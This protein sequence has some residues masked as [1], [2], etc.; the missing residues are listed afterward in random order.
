MSY[1]E[2][3]DELYEEQKSMTPDQIAE[4]MANNSEYS[5][6]LNNLPGVKHVWVDRGAVMSC[7]GA[8]H[9]SHR[10]FKVKK[11]RV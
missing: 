11:H 10:H 4:D 8:N 1:A 2:Q 6:D 7:E 5:I 3:L 9:P